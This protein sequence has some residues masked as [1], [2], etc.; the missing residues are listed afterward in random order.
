[1]HNAHNKTDHTEG[2]VVGDDDE[3][4]DSHNDDDDNNNNDNDGGCS[5]RDGHCQMRKGRGLS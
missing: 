4:N 2:G 5:G 3:E 1:M